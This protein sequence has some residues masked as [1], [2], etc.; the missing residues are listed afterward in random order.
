[1][2]TA[3]KKTVRQLGNFPQALS[4]LPLIEAMPGMILLKR[5]AEL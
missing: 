1:M 2:S 5:R 4:H 3:N